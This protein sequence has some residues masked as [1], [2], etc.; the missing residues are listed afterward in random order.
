MKLNSGQRVSLFSA[1]QAVHPE[2][3]LLFRSPDDVTPEM[4][5]EEIDLVYKLK[6]EAHERFER[7]KWH[8]GDLLCFPEKSVQP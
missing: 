8:L 3:G 4:L 6:N 5:Q 1:G 7:Y 2:L